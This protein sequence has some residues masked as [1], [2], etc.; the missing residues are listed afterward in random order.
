MARLAKPTLIIHGDQEQAS[1]VA[2]A[3]RLDAAVPTSTYVVVPQAGHFA[4]KDNPE[5]FNQALIHFL[6]TLSRGGA[7]V[8]HGP[9]F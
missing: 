7:E 8:T 2:A 4:Q 5:V 1:I 6:K 9:T 3:K